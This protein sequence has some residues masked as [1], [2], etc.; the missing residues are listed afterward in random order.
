M[1]NGFFVKAVVGT[2]G[3]VWL[4]LLV[5]HGVVDPSRALW[6]PYSLVVSVAGG[7]TW[8]F[9][10]WFWSWPGISLLV[11]RPDLRGTW[12]GE[13]ASN[14]IDPKTKSKLPPI[15]AFVCITQT[16]TALHIRQ[17]TRE[18]ESITLA[19]TVVTEADDAH[20][21]AAVYRNE[22]KTSVR[23]RSEIHRGGMHLRVAGT[24]TLTGDYWTDR[25]TGGELTFERIS[26]A[27]AKSFVE[28]EQL[29]LQ[30]K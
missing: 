5:F 27:K 28:G 29:P 22:P 21:V 13:I 2:C 24:D 16:A 12:R 15:P 30:R 14:W 8:A 9:D 20:A 25:P 26:R 4:G 23:E 1:G 7:L 3:V 19:A 10:R 6:G 18:S 17:F 11:K